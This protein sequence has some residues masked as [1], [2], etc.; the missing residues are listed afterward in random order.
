MIVKMVCTRKMAFITKDKVYKV[1]TETDYDEV[2]SVF[3][4]NGSWLYYPEE[5]FEPLRKNNLKKIICHLE[6]D[7]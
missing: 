6:Q 4:D 5:F 7:I 2:F 3:S 1:R